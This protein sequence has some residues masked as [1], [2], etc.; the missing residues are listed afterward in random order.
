MNA[1]K[2]P[3]VLLASATELPF[4]DNHFDTV[5]TDPPY[6]D[7]CYGRYYNIKIIELASPELIVFLHELAHAVDVKAYMM[8]RYRCRR[9]L[10]SSHLEY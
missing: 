2:I 7:N 5:F 4:P 8:D 9:L 10:P 6:Y 1:I 3:Y